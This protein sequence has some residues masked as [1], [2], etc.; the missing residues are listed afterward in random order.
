MAESASELT[1]SFDT[2]TVVH[3]RKHAGT[4]ACGRDQPIQEED[5]AELFEIADSFEMVNCPECLK[6]LIREL[7]PLLP[8][9][10]A[11]R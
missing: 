1:M 4:N 10:H 3:L 7:A 6:V 5:W 8:T 9:L 2:E 11:K